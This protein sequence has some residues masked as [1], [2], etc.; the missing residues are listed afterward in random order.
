MRKHN[1]MQRGKHMSVDVMDVVDRTESLQ[2]RILQELPRSLRDVINN[3]SNRVT[4]QDLFITWS[5][6]VNQEKTEK[7][8]ID[9]VRNKDVYE[10]LLSSWGR[11]MS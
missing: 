7:E 6:Y 3:A 9:W 2:F 8:L 4:T 1:G 5:H 11:K 10:D